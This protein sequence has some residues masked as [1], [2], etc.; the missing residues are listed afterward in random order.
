VT[1]YRIVVWSC[2]FVGILMMS[3]CA[4][5]AGKPSQ[6]KFPKVSLPALY[7]DTRMQ[8]EFLAMHYWDQFD[9]NDTTWIGSAEA[10]T[11]QALTEYLSILPYASYDVICKG[12]TQLLDKADVNQAMYA[13]FYSK[14]EYYLSNSSST[15]RNQELY[16]PVLEHMVQAKSLD[17]PRKARPKAILPL[18]NKNRPGTTAANIHFTRPSGAKDSLTTIKSDLILVIFYDFECVDCNVL[19]AKMNESPVVNELIKRKKLA[20]L[21]IYPGAN[22]EGWKKSLPQVPTTWINGYDHNEEIGQLGT[23]ILPS[24]PTLYLLDGKYMVIMKEQPFEYV[25]AYLNSILNP[26]TN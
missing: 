8:S 20:I 7:N 24:I 13:F 25:E 10:T 5:N 22:M 21:A 9:F 2:V 12:I 14:M 16:I 23:Y 1:R 11:E 3:G 6:K 4:N 15:L 17:E 19:K 18:L 26:P